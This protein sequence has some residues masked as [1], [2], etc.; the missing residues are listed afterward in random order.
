MN[1]EKYLAK[2]KKLLNLARKATNQNEAA[3]ALR[4]AQNL[5]REHN[6]SEMD[7][8]STAINEASSHGAP[9]N[10]VTPP[11]YLSHLI[12]V[13]RRAFGVEALLSWRDGKYD[14]SPQRRVVTFYG[15]D[16]RPQIAAYAF[17][18]LSRQMV[19]AR[20]EYI[21]GLHRNT[22]PANRTA[23]ADLFCEGWATG[24]YNIVTRL[25]PT[26]SEATLM[27]LYCERHYPDVSR[28]AV[29]DARQCANSDTARVAGILAGRQAQLAHGVDGAASET[30]LI[31]GGV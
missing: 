23:K 5:M 18:V 9:N 2:I 19:A 29:R 21:D 30:K 24:V 17:D 14:Y 20:K 12:S 3:A 13:I 26:E 16:N 11:R 27:A 15:P 25:A 1:K 6:V 31:G 10:A 7:A 8:E 22:K 28:S 4:Q